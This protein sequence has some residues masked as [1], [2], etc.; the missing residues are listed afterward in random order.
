MSRLEAR[1]SKRKTAVAGIVGRRA[2]EAKEKKIRVCLA[3]KPSVYEEMKELG[4]TEK[5]SVSEIVGELMEKYVEAK[6]EKQG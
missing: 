3:V 1:E 6:R 4:F 2:E 5:R